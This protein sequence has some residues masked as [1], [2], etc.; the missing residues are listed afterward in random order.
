MTAERPGAPPDHAR[1][2]DHASD[3][4][5]ISVDAMGGDEGPAAVIGGLELAAEQNGTITFLLHGD[6]AVL[7]PM[8]QRK[9]GLAARCTVVHAPAAVTMTDKPSHVVRHGQDTSMWST[10]ESVRGG[11]ATV[12]VSCG[13]T[14][15][16]MALSMMRLRKLPGV[17]RPAIACLWPSRNPQGFNV[18][19]DVGADVRADAEDLL[20]YALMGAA[21]ARNGLGL[22]RPRVGLLNVGTEEHKGRAELRAALEMIA[23]AAP[24][25]GFEAVGF[26]EGSDIPSARVDVIVTDGFT[27]NVALKTGEGTARL[28]RDFMGEAFRKS[29]LSKM[30][31]LLAL[32]SLRRLQKRIDPR[33]VNGGVF[34]GLN[35]TVVKSHGAAD[36]TGV[37]AAVRL[38]VTLAQAGFQQA[39][40][41]RMAGAPP[42]ATAQAAPQPTP[43]AEPLPADQSG[44]RIDGRSLDPVPGPGGGT[45]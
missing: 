33:R 45:P 25:G 3:A 44:P 6:R 42:Q 15:A 23:E 41:Q 9:P 18:M 20:Q 31:A 17:N 29:L 36:A 19:L 30:A 35:G 26:V 1:R 21:Y 43:Q 22:E 12:A 34:L 40:A 38:A 37:A 10:L 24:G 11:A 5:V 16:L 27:G 14:G 39:L 2:R 4:V 32:T 7:D 8:L 28:V 13:N